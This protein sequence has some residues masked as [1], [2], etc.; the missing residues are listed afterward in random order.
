MLHLFRGNIGS[1]LLAMGDAFKNGGIIFA[2][3]M[4]TILGIICVHS[5]HLLVRLTLLIFFVLL[6]VSFPAAF[7]EKI[8]C[9]FVRQ[10]VKG[11]QLE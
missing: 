10:F 11:N 4:T 5:Q 8:V 3:I 2:P 7:E 1:G 9:H 6:P